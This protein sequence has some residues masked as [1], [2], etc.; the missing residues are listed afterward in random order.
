MICLL[1][2]GITFRAML[3]DY[4]M[5]EKEQT[6]HNHAVAMSRLASVYHASGELEERWGS[7]RIALTSA[8][9]VSGSDA[10]LCYG[11]YSSR[12]ME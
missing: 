4:L 2:L 10:M 5:E 11:F 3:R 12:C 8:S 1:V 9:R 7:F 6:L